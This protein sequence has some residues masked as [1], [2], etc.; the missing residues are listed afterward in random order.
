MNRILFI[1]LLAGVSMLS[2]ARAQELVKVGLLELSNASSFTC[3]SASG[4]HRLISPTGD[5][6]QT[7]SG[8]LTVR[9]QSGKLSV[10][11]LPDQTHLIIQPL[12][13]GSLLRVSVPG[14]GLRK[15]PGLVHLFIHNG[16]I[17][18]VLETPLEAYLPGVVVAEGG[19]GH[20][21][22][23]Y[24]AQSIVCRTYTIQAL[25]RHAIEGFDV[26]D[27]VHCQVFKGVSTVNDTI[28]EGVWATRDLILVDEQK[29]PIVAAFH[30]N[31]GGHTQGAE[32]V[33][34]R[35][36][37]YLAGVSDAFC[38]TYPHSHWEQL[39]STQKWSDWL[40][41]E[42]GYESEIDN[43][44]P[45]KR[46]AFLMDSVDAIRTARARSAFGFRSGFFIALEEGDSTRVIGQGFG[47]GV[48]F[49]QE[50]AMGRAA[51]G[52]GVW[53]ILKHYYR[54]VSLLPW[55]ESEGA[56]VLKDLG[57]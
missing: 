43:W 57:E 39:I 33:W 40:E 52:H 20:A 37:P 55:Q 56:P 53:E 16:S 18:C 29:Q 22:N 9:R 4:A 50:G 11:G 46:S 19:K 35:A 17:R 32:A 6:A 36:V 26:C 7:I 30:S 13:D 24:Q 2:A 31:C 25:G 8:K 44:L 34:Q 1:A 5:F 42:R 51:A 14:K 47:H 3:S 12:I 45:T 38:L 49:C 23:Y 48:G 28:R 21:P 15:M 10:S 27:G 41:S 54:G